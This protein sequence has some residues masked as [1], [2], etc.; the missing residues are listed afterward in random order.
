LLN[1]VTINAQNIDFQKLTGPYLGQTLPDRDFKQFAP[2]IVPR[3]MFNSVTVSPDG[4]EIYWGASNGILFTKLVN[5]Y[6]TTPTIVPVSGKSERKFCDDAPVISPDNTKLF[7][8]SRRRTNSDNSE[9]VRIWF[10][11]RT[12][13][14]WS[15]PMPLPDIINSCF[16]SE[17]Q[18]S[19]ANSGTIYFGKN[20]INREKDEMRFLIYYSRLINGVYITPEPL[21]VLNDFGD[22]NCPFIAPDESYIIF[23]KSE[24]IPAGPFVPKG[25][26][27]SFKGKDNRWL[28]PQK[29][30]GFPTTGESSFI[31][32]DGKY[33]FCKELWASAK[34][35]EELRPKE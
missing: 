17:W 19:V 4:K 5:G 26:Y 23:N 18:I 28:T 15:E 24:R 14:G 20:I 27:I 32:R 12:P 30:T 16:S 9:K 25:Y 11:D 31:T 7:F 22:V 13:S 33:V 8:I 3:N 34:I 2:G 29:L 35:I 1:T 6:W 10:S 21:S